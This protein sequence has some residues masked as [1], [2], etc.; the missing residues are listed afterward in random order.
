ME[1]MKAR[2]QQVCYMFS[3]RGMSDVLISLSE[4]RGS[5]PS[6]MCFSQESAQHPFPRNGFFRLEDGNT[7]L[8]DANQAILEPA[9]ATISSMGSAGLLSEQIPDK[10]AV[11]GACVSMANASRLMY[12]RHGP[13]GI[14]S[15]DDVRV[16]Y[17]KAVRLSF[18][19]AA[20]IL[21]DQ[22]KASDNSEPVLALGDDSECGD[23]ELRSRVSEAFAGLALIAAYEREWNSVVSY[24][25]ASL[26][27]HT[28]GLVFVTG[29]R[30]VL[31]A[32][33]QPRVERKLIELALLPCLYMSS[34]S[35]VRLLVVR[36]MQLHSPESRTAMLEYARA[37]KVKLD[38]VRASAPAGAAIIRTTVPFAV[39]SD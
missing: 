6:R 33:D 21:L 22:V 17:E 15:L 7:A 1:Q 19:T 30:L 14:S 25:T 24:A 38:R 4:H 37:C 18:N 26:I 13:D 34:D 11:V 3:A 31:I 27:M 28:D 16:G 12:E 20:S 23:A 35:Q 9:F 2:I 32:M 8:I 39:P 29:V 36:E 10:L 5:K